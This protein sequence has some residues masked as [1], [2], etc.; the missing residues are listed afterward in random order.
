MK[1]DKAIE[2]V[3]EVRHRISAEFGHDLDKYFS[4]LQ[5]EQEKYREQINRFRRLDRPLPE[6]ETEEMALR[7]QPKT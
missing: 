7:E 5:T 2:E 3:R 4:Y 6:P 1:T